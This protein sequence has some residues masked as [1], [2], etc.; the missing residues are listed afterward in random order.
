[1]APIPP[2]SPVSALSHRRRRL[3]L[4]R[5]VRRWLRKL[6][7]DERGTTTLEWA[8]LLGGIALPA[9]YLLTMC[10]SV[11]VDYYRMMTMLSSLPTP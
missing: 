7:R 6:H 10:L 8:L 1:M 3:P 5:R 9:V 11:V 4:T 2:S